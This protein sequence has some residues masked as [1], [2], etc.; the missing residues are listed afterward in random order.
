MSI[1]NFGDYTILKKLGAGSFGDIYLAQHRFIKNKV[2]IKVLSE[3]LSSNENFIKNFEKDVGILTTLDHP[4]IV[5]VH[6]ISRA[7]GQYFIVMDAIVDT[8]NEVLSLDRYLRYKGDVLPEIEVETILRQIASALDYAHKIKFGDDFLAHR[9]L[10]LNNIFVKNAENGLRVYV[11]DFGLTRLIGEGKVLFKSQQLL[12]NEMIKNDELIKN[13]KPDVET[14]YKFLENYSFLSPE[15]KFK[16]LNENVSYKT[17]IYSFGILAYYLIVKE[18]PEGYFDLP[19]KIAPE[20]KLNWDLLICKCL[21]KDPN[22]RP[23]KLIEALNSFLSTEQSD[24][25]SLEILSWE[26]VEK[27]VENAMQMSFEF[28]SDFNKL[29]KDLEDSNKNLKFTSVE[30]TDQKPIIKPQKVDRPTFEADPGAI[31]QKE[32]NVSYYQPK[33]VEIKEVDPILTEMVI[34][35][36]GLY[37]RGSDKGSRD[38]KPKHKITINSFALDIHPVTNEQFTRFLEFMGGE[39]DVSNNDIIRLRSSRIKRSSGK[40]II[41]SGYAKHPV[42]GITWYG[43]VAYAK[44]VGKRL[45]TEA[46]WEIAASGGI[47]NGEYPTGINIDHSQANFFNSDTTAV[48]SYPTNGYGLYDMVGNVYEWCEDWYAYNFYDVTLQ[49]PENP[50]G[51]QQGVYRVLRGGCWKS[52]KEDMRCSHRHRNNP[53]TVNGTYGFRCAADV[54]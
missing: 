8:N 4:T 9:S 46:E 38:E 15:Q 36:G 20:Y 25:S 16:D 50:K 48:M 51:P 10:K 37:S 18:F 12:L 39:K 42:V 2:A 24:I 21:Q 27:K 14:T 47:E 6:D 23:E 40:L 54:S 29:E 52:L 33:K 30:E 28:S 13:N 44:W 49:E 11:S 19:S 32:L 41:E 22:R 26:E 5:K 1:K 17:D 7:D 31:F 35:P 34:I 43:A 3:E 53:G 45:P